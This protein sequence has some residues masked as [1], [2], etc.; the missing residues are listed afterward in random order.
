M[1]YNSESPILKLAKKIVATRNLTFLERLLRRTHWGTD[2][3]RPL[4]GLNIS[5]DASELVDATS[6]S[7]RELPKLVGEFL[8]AGFIQDALTEAGWT[9]PHNDPGTEVVVKN[10]ASE[11]KLKYNDV[12][13]ATRSYMRNESKKSAVVAEMLEESGIGPGLGIDARK[14]SRKQKAVKQKTVK[15]SETTHKGF[16]VGQKVTHIPTGRKFTVIGFNPRRYKN[17]I[18]IQGSQGGKYIASPDKLRDGWGKV[19]KKSKTK[20]ST[21]KTKESYLGFTIGQKA[22]YLPTRSKVTVIGFLPNRW[23]YPI[24]V[25]GPRGGQYIVSPGQLK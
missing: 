7:A 18:R 2:S 24:L 22:T 14:K 5:K 16:R 23:K 19:A 10:V 4:Y 13:A 15:E 8:G 9:H 17:S 1:S 6:I 20:K 11:L 12:L 25:E 21:K 3:R